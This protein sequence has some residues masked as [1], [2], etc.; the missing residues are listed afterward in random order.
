MSQSYKVVRLEENTEYRL[1]ICASNEA[2]TGPY[3]PVAHFSTVKAP[4]PP[5]KRKHGGQ[6]MATLQIPI[7]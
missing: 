5:L 3:S 6:G 2:G 4:P 1:R 7:V